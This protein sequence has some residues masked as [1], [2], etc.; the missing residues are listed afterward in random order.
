MTTT[1]DDLPRAAREAQKVP[2]LERATHAV[3]ADDATHG[4]LA[5]FDDAATPDAVLTLLR[6]R[7]EAREALAD[8]QEECEELREQCLPPPRVVPGE[9]QSAEALAF[10]VGADDSGGLLAMPQ[11]TLRIFGESHEMLRK[12]RDEAQ[13][14][15]QAATFRLEQLTKLHETAEAELDEARRMAVALV[16]AGLAHTCRGAGWDQSMLPENWRA[17][18]ER[19]REGNN[20]ATKEK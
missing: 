19:W 9:V 8:A 15:V 10:F 13:L 16:D 4:D 20:E 7:D 3:M 18:V 14:E 2:D 12:E 5:A 17:T 6:E 1:K 11:R